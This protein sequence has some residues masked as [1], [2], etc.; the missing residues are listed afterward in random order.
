MDASL[1]S[2]QAALDAGEDTRLP[3][4][5]GHAVMAQNQELLVAQLIDRSIKF[6]GVDVMLNFAKIIELV[7]C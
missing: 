4:Y 3:V 1:V 2:S 7:R 5:A 6:G